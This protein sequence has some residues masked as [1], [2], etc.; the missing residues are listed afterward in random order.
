MKERIQYWDICKGLAMFLVVWGHCLQNLTTD[1]GYWLSDSASEIIISFHMPLFM[2]VSGYFAYSSLWKTFSQ[3]MGKKVVQLLLPSVVWG[4][5]VSSAAMLVH[6][7]FSAERFQYILTITLYSFWFLKALFMCYLITMIGAY[8]YRKW[9]VWGLLVV[10]LLLLLAGEPLNYSSTISML[11]FFCA[12]LFLKRYENEIFGRPKSF[13]IGSVFI[14]AICMTIWQSG[15]YNLYLHPFTWNLGGVKCMLIRSLIG[16]SGSLA[17]ILMIKY[18]SQK[19]VYVKFWNLMAHIGSM[20]LGIYL[21][22]VML[23]EGTLKVFSRYVDDLILRLPI[24]FQTFT[25]DLIITPLV[26]CL[27]IGVC[28]P[29]IYVIRC[30]KTSKF[31]LLGEK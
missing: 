29:T 5:I 18:I 1:N 6:R 26:A 20:T 2:L 3:V 21:I 13:L 22:Q 7:D 4:L 19:K 14:Y 24:M 30:N 16:I 25:Y 11:P 17:V 28:V 23:A 15:D 9:Y 31:L 12:G 27:V 10:V 8:A